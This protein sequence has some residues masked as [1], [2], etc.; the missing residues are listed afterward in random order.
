M[1]NRLMEM[2]GRDAALD[3]F[4]TFRPQLLAE[5]RTIALQF[6]KEKGRV[7]SS[8]VIERMVAKFPQAMASVDHRFMGGVFRGGWERIGFEPSGSH[9]RP[10]SVWKL[11]E[12]A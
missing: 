11:K 2:R 4:E 3:L 10:V 1:R 8:E 6:A 5:A 9:C 7:T 12:A